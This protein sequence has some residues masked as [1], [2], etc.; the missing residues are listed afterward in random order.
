MAE[1]RRVATRRKFIER[2]L[3]SWETEEESKT[4]GKVIPSHTRA[5][6][7]PQPTGGSEFVIRAPPILRDN[8]GFGTLS[9]FSSSL[10]LPSPTV[11]LMFSRTSSLTVLSRSCR[12]LLRPNNNIQRASFSLTARS[13][14]AIN[15]A[16]AD[17][18]GITADSLKN[19]LTEV[20]QAQHVEVEDLSGMEF[21]I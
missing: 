16:M 5:T 6:H 11:Y 10:P 8:L 3:T 4:N 19:K 15:A 9:L 13:H 14:A 18:S 1:Y 2:Q 20:L 7:Q 21:E 17:T 12:Y